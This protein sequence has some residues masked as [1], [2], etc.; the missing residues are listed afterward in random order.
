MRS[1]MYAIFQRVND[2]ENIWDNRK[3]EDATAEPEWEEFENLLYVIAEFIFGDR[4]F[5]GV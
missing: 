4:S 3:V 5:K 2:I 1:R